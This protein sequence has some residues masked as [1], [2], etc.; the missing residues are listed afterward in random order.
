MIIQKKTYSKWVS[1]Q[2]NFNTTFRFIYFQN[3]KSKQ[4]CQITN[5]IRDIARLFCHPLLAFHPALNSLMKS[6]WWFSFV[7]TFFLC[8]PYLS[9]GSLAMGDMNAL[10]WLPVQRSSFLLYLLLPPHFDN[11]WFLS[12]SWRLHSIYFTEKVCFRLWREKMLDNPASLSICQ[13]Q[14]K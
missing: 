6:F 3:S 9:W 11:T 4:I 12:H 7:P 2:N 13:T 14:P 8:F 10:V 5:D 1:I